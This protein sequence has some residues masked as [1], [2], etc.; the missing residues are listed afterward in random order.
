MGKLNYNDDIPYL[1]NQLF[2]RWKDQRNY[3]YFV[4]D[5]VFNPQIWKKQKIK[6]T[7]VLK[8]A[9]WMN[10]NVDMKEWIL[11][12][13]SATYWKT[14]NNVSRWTKGILEGGEYPVH[15]SKKDKTDWLSRIS[16]INLKKV[17]GNSKAN[18]KE[19]R[20]Y[21]IRDA[22]YLLEQLTIYCPDIIICCGRG[23]GKNADLLY[24]E[25]LDKNTLS[26]W[27]IPI[28]G[29]NYFYTHFPGKENRTPVISFYHPQRIASHATFEKWYEDICFIAE[30]LMC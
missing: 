4:K 30:K 29:F 2:S 11:S 16:F 8:E 15:V 23:T 18:N 5:G 10:E 27:Q 3:E 24:E 14:W 17:G 22:K 12:E 1:E 26:Q 25:I 28:N 20:Q 19:I 9:N 21:A 7:F 13:S 6:I